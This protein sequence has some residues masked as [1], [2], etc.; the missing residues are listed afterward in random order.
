[1]FLKAA[2]EASCEE[3]DEIR[4]EPSRGLVEDPPGA[5][6]LLVTA[7]RT[8][9]EGILEAANYGDERG[10]AEI[11][12]AAAL[13]EGDAY[14]LENQGDHLKRYEKGQRKMDALIAEG[15]RSSP[16]LAVSPGNR[17]TPEPTRIQGPINHLARPSKTS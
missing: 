4:P 1:M 3:P 9:S 12:E 5:S 17:K 11:Y 15:R 6:D 13:E 10:Q 2:K 7:A 16:C 14:E 8:P